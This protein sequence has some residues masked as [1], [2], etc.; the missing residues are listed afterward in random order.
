MRRF[1]LGLPLAALVVLLALFVPAAAA[2]PPPSLASTAQYLAFVE[3][4][5]KLD[6]LAGQPTQA[7]QKDAYQAELTA[8]KEAAAH[9]A[10]A[11]FNRASEEA[12]AEA[13]AKYKEQ[14]GAVRGK[15]EEELDGLQAES[16]AKLRKAGDS[17]HA[18]LDRLVSGHRKHEAR[19]NEQ[20]AALRGQKA[21]TPDPAQKEAIQ[22][23]ISA[24]IEE[25][26][27]KHEE[28]KAK[29]ATLK[30]GFRQQKEELHAAEAK[31]ETEI[32]EAAE[33]QVAKIA[34][35]WKHAAE[36][37]KATLGAKRDS[38]LAYLETKLAK[39]RADVASMPAAG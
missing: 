36:E 25:L 12:E 39:G 20:I 8:K 31:K 32:G 1:G 17:Y 14:A 28:E 22:A 34:A 4:V 2:K 15:E 38:Q 27:G 10:N 9:K 24:K 29:R 5:K 30:A 16:A 35:H 19:V 7:A 11:L 26:K 3:F 21:Q 6:G 18:K 33:A 23:Q 13:N 37:K